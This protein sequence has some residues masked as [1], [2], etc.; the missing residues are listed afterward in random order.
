MSIDMRNCRYT[1]SFDADL[2]K[3]IQMVEGQVLADRLYTQD[4]IAIAYEHYQKG[5]NSV[6]IVCPGFYNSKKN[7]WMR[8]TIDLISSKYDVIIFDFRGHGDSGGKFSWTAKEHLDVQAVID[9]AQDQNYKE[10]NIVAFSLGAAAAVNAVSARD[11]VDSMVLISCPCE[12]RKIDY[13]FWKPEMISDLKDNIEC[14]WEGKGARTTGVFLKKPK[15]TKTIA[16]IKHIPILFIHGD[17]DWIIKAYH[18]QRLYD[19]AK[20]YKKIK[21]IEGGLHAER[22]IQQQPTEMKNLILEW[23]SQ[24]TKQY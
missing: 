11:G 14:G 10:I 8:K 4:K 12:F 3:D 6:V 21:I 18:S 9:Y 13:Y 22:L 19:V 17:R 24:N 16:K 2:N 5:F 20:T 7:R 15:P 1:K 23:F